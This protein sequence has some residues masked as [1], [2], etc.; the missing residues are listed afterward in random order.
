MLTQS[1]IYGYLYSWLKLRFGYIVIMGD[2]QGKGCL[3]RSEDWELIFDET[4]EIRELDH[5][6]L[7]AVDTSEESN[8]PSK[9]YQ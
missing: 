7:K 9:I 2:A 8:K 6:L 5:L 1:P 4:K 3:G